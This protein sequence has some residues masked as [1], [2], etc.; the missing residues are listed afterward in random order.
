MITVISTYVCLYV[1]MFSFA[2]KAYKS[3][4]LMKTVVTVSIRERTFHV[5]DISCCV[6]TLDSR[7]NACAVAFLQVHT[8]KAFESVL[9]LCSVLTSKFSAKI[10]NTTIPGG[11]CC[12]ANNNFRV[13]HKK[14]FS[15]F[16]SELNSQ[17][18][19]LRCVWIWR[20]VNF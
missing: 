6:S 9:E 12:G 19:K 7:E 14:N 11:N 13:F 8:T 1:N 16:H 18:F 10:L 15:S 5:Q 2:W 20:K 17:Q 3:I 4:H